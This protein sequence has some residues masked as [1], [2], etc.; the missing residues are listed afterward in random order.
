MSKRNFVGSKSTLP[1]RNSIVS[2]TVKLPRLVYF[3]IDNRGGGGIG[4]ATLHCLADAC[5]GHVT[6]TSRAYFSL[7]QMMATNL[8]KTALCSIVTEPDCLA[9]KQAR[10]FL[11]ASERMQPFEEFCSNLTKKT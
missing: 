8:V 2:S 1:Y 3:I 7:T 6:R 5:H 4:N 9:R 11:R 10:I